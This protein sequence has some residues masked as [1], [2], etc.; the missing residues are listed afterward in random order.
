VSTGAEAYD[1][2]NFPRRS[3]DV[4]MLNKGLVAIAL[5]MVVVVGG[6]MLLC[7]RASAQESGSAHESA[8]TPGVVIQRSVS[9]G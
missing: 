4:K 8:S 9:L 6:V 1:A 2:F 7:A 3:N 5:K